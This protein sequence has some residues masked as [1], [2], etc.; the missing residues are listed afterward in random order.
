[1]IFLLP[2]FPA[3]FIPVCLQMHSG[4]ARFAGNL[5]L[6]KHQVAIANNIVTITEYIRLFDVSA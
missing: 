2:T 4:V 3:Y 5:K 1:M 6:V